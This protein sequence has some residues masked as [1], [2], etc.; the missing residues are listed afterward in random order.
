M[1]LW[2]KHDPAW[3]RA[4]AT[5]RAAIRAQSLPATP[6]PA[7]G[8]H[9]LLRV[10]QATLPSPAAVAAGNGSASGR[11]LFFSDLHWD[12][13]DTAAAAPLLATINAMDADWLVFGG[14]LIMYMQFVPAA[15]AILGQLRARRGKFAV[16]GNWERRKVWCPV[17]FWREA[18]AQAGFRLLVNEVAE[19]AGVTFVGYDDLRWGKPDF[20]VAAPLSAQ[21][22][23]IGVAHEPHTFAHLG[24]AFAGQLLLSG[25][26]HAGQVRLPGFG[27]LHTSNPYWKHFEQGWY[28]HRPDGRLLHITAGLGCTGWEWL[29]RRLFCPPEILLVTVGPGAA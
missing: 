25:H 15:M 6:A 7:T 10:C 3:N 18:Y 21:H 9:R 20:R 5:E 22:P 17:G 16:F 29:R 4:T 23:V 24:N 14:D 26:T 28:R 11:L 27:A 1:R 12:K 8:P 2:P 19:S 13:H